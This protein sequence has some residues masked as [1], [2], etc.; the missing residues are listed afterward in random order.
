MAKGTETNKRFDI[1]KQK[2]DVYYENFYFDD[3]RNAFVALYEY[4]FNP[5]EYFGTTINKPNGPAYLNF[6]TQWDFDK[7]DISMYYYGEFP[8]S[9]GNK[10]LEK[11]LTIREKNFF[12]DF[13]IRLFTERYTKKP[14][15]FSRPLTAEDRQFFM[16]ADKK[17]IYGEYEDH[18]EYGE[19]EESGESV[20]NEEDD[21]EHEFKISIEFDVQF[22]ETDAMDEEV[23]FKDVSDAFSRTTMTLNQANDMGYWLDDNSI[24][25]MS[26]NVTTMDYD[27]ADG[28]NA[29]EFCY[30]CLDE[31]DKELRKAGC[32]MA[33][34]KCS[35]AKD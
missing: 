24:L 5:D 18:E 30:E 1:T 21:D 27:D 16:D 14:S 32:R 8:E 6:V 28:T 22:P 2:L 9:E 34:Q 17:V 19:D 35:I 7:D 29:M 4:D 3:S 23:T 12:R 20:E 10:E 25:Y 15:F 31:A 26:F 33:N 11:K 13:M